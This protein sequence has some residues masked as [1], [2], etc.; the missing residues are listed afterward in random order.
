MIDEI[1]SGQALFRVCDGE[2]LY[3]MRFMPEYF[4]G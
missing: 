1:C 4:W 2:C 3:V